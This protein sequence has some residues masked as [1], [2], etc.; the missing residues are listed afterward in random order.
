MEGALETTND[1]DLQDA[2]TRVCQDFAKTTK[3]DLT[4]SPKYSVDDVLEQI[5]T[6]QEADAERGGKYKQVK[7]FVDKTITFI[8]VIGGIVAQGASMVS[9]E[10]VL[11]PSHSKPSRAGVCTQQSMFQCP[12]LSSQYGCQVQED[13]HWAFR[14]IWENMRCARSLEDLYGTSEGV[15]AC[16]SSDDSQ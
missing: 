10:R 8:G 15:G 4:V 16:C 9:I 7:D 13:L 12:F 6:R 14:A 11:T 2:W 3:V 1:Y 5:R